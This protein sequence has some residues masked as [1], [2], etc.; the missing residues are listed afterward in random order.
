MFNLLRQKMSAAAVL[1][2]LLQAAETEARQDGQSQPG[3]EHLVLAAL[4]LP[5]GEAV[6]ALMSLDLTGDDVRG[7][8]ARQYDEPLKSLGIER[9]LDTQPLGPVSKA[10]LY[11]AAPSG[12][13]LIQALAKDC[14]SP[15]TS[16]RVLL[17][18]A[19]QSHG[20]LPRALKLLGVDIARFREAA[21]AA[22]A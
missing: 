10:S 2:E 18:A 12:Q 17:A 19:E 14:R 4:S 9:S 7:A 1:S 13:A 6:R 8:I 22:Q 21:L 11:R 15:L 16:A 20:V 3:A 5:D